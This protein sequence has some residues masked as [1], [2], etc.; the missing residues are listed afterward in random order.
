[1]TVQWGSFESIASAVQSGEVRAVELA[2]DALADAAE[3]DRRVDSGEHVGSL[4]GVPFG[5]KDLEDAAG[6][7]TRFGSLLSSE[8]PVDRDSILVGRLKAAGAVVVG[9]TATPE[10]GHKAETISLVS[11][12]TLNPIDPRRSPG[13]SSGGS[14]AALAADMVPLATGSDGGGSIRIP[15]ALCG[16]PGLKTTQ[17]LIP[18]GGPN[19]PG[20][21]LFTVKGPMTRTCA[22]LAVALDV[23]TGAH[24][25][26]PF[27]F[28]SA[29][30]QFVAHLGDGLPEKLAWS[31][32]MGFATVDEAVLSVCQ[33][34]VD[35][36]RDAG[37]TIVTLD[38]V[39]DRDPVGAWFSQWTALRAAAQSQFRGTDQ[40]ERIDPSLRFLIEWGE[41][42]TSID[43]I[44]G[45]NDVFRLNAQLAKV[46]EQ[47]PLLIVPTC[48]GQ[49]PTSGAEGMV[50]GER[51]AAWVS[52]TYGFNVSRNPAGTIPCGTTA[53]GM[54]V[55]LQ[56]VGPHH[57]D[58]QVL[59]AM[60]ACE[61]RWLG[62]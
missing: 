43:V 38:S 33:A 25:T 16:L 41:G 26:D 61:R 4:A 49:T 56:I 28:P 12:A 3:V 40:W 27:S 5:V 20:S 54:P 50:N 11:G 18:N 31:P 46:W 6:F 51:T 2:E 57:A 34:A 9:K 19:P 59:A 52:F 29:P 53:G 17:G 45:V 8:L 7:P 10:W 1:M 60:A 24:W 13:G 37:H 44:E 22:D 58:A 35:D 21:G 55:G 30:G 47:A 23:V 48:A 62:H 36:L 42:L 14:A 32:T 15:A 39:W